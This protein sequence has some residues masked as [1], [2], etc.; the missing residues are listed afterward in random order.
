MSSLTW[1]AHQY[2]IYRYDLKYP[3]L[4]KCN[5]NAYISSRALLSCKLVFENEFYLKFILFGIK[6]TSQRKTT[7]EIDV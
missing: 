4:I 1:K 5:F 7:Y 3:I 2:E 6:P